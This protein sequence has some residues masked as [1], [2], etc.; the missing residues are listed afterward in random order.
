[1]VEVNG[2]VPSGRVNETLMSLGSSPPGAEPADIFTAE[3]SRFDGLIV[4]KAEADPP[5]ITF[6]IIGLSCNVKVLNFFRPNKGIL[7]TNVI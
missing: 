4:A 1:M 6:S 2:G 5:G 7:L 3:T